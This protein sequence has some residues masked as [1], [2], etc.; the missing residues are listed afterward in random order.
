MTSRSQFG[1]LLAPSRLCGQCRLQDRVNVPAALSNTYFNQA[2]QP[3]KSTTISG[4]IVMTPHGSGPEPVGG[5][6]FDQC[7]GIIATPSA[8]ITL[9]TVLAPAA[10]PRM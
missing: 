9:A 10:F 6:V 3:E 8:A 1:E 2:L 5:L 4:G 7:E